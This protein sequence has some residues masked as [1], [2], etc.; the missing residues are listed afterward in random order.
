L[1]G[2]IALWYFVRQSGVHATVAGVMLAFIIPT[3]TRINAVQFSREGRALVNQFD[4]GET[5]DFLVLTS[6]RQQKA[7]FALKHAS[8]G[9][10]APILGLETALHNFSAVV[11]MPLFAIANAGVTIG[12]SIQHAEIT[13]GV[14][15]GL[16]IGKPL[17][18]MAAVFLGVKSGIAELPATVG[19]TSLLGYAWLAGIGFT[20]SLLIAML[21]VRRHCE[22]R[23]SETWHSWGITACRCCWG[24]HS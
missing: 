17:G 10:T 16:V 9:V 21:A 4:R 14:L 8:E 22:P 2:G 7:L 6:K 23:R 3:H 20:L 11:I 1:F 12:L 24:D 5:G 15:A 13:L 18:T 19:W